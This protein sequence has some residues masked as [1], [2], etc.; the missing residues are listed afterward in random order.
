MRLKLKNISFSVFRLPLF[1]LWFSE[2]WRVLGCN[3]LFFGARVSKL[4][5]SEVAYSLLVWFFRVKGVEQWR[6]QWVLCEEVVD[7]LSKLIK[8]SATTTTTTTTR[9]SQL[10]EWCLTFWTCFRWKDERYGGWWND[11]EGGWVD[12]QLSG[13][14]DGW[15]TE[16]VGGW[17]DEQLNGWVDLWGDCCQSWTTTW[18]VWWNK[19]LTM[20][21]CFW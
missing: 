9:L 13:W 10:V 19:I 6:R 21:P 15:T 14:M 5:S 18:M 2:P 3:Y 12:E 4:N 7:T 11:W 20:M 17:L 16:W 8:T 1:I